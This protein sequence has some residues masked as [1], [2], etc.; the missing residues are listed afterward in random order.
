[1][2]YLIGLSLMFMLGCSTLPAI[3]SQAPRNCQQLNPPPMIILTDEIRSAIGAQYEHEIVDLHRALKI[4]R[5]R[6]GYDRQ[7]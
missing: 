5:D 7:R 1:M 6:R 3:P 4:C 2:K